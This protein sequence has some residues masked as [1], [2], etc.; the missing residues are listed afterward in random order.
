M[1]C[2]I[3]GASLTILG[4]GVKCW[5]CGHFIDRDDTEESDDDD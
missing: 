3:C 1:I 4:T 2:P 5:Q